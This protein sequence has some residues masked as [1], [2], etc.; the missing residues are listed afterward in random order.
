MSGLL[1]LGVCRVSREEQRELLAGVSL[2]SGCFW[3]LLWGWFALSVGG[4]FLL[5]RNITRNR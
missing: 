5:F 2:S 3:W 1:W 4:G